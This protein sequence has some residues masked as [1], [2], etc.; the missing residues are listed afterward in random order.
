MEPNTQNILF[1][2]KQV[3][4]RLAA[5]PSEQVE[6]LA[7]LGVLPSADELALEFDD[8]VAL[9]PRLVDE[10]NL[11]PERYEAI[12]AL[13]RKLSEMSNRQDVWTEVSLRSHPDWAEVRRL[14]L[15]VIDKMDGAW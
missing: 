11:T 13:R 1:E 14:A 2:L 4:G 15:V 9:L 7:T 12:E 6:Y 10:G 5:T 3:V 8:V